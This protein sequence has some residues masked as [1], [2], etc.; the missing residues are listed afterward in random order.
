MVAFKFNTRVAG[1]GIAPGLEDYA[2]CL[3]LLLG[4]S[5]YILSRQAGPWRIVSTE[6]PHHEW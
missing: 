4:V 1:P 3:L 6:P 2:N 5:D